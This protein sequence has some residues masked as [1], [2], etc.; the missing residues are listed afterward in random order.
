[1]IS[2]RDEDEAVAIANDVDYGLHGYVYGGAENVRVRS[3]T[4]CKQGA[5]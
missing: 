4:A 5:R 3:R 2:Y 1:M